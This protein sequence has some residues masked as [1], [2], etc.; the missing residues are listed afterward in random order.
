LD[1]ISLDKV[2]HH[3]FF[4]AKLAEAVPVRSEGLQFTDSFLFRYYNSN[5]G[6]FSQWDKCCKSIKH[7]K[8]LKQSTKYGSI[9][10]LACGLLVYEPVNE[11]FKLV[12]STDGNYLYECSLHVFVNDSHSLSGEKVHAVDQLGPQL[13]K[14][15]KYIMKF[16]DLVKSKTPSV[17][18]IISSDIVCLL[19]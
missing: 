18:N 1:R 3:P 7:L 15:H 6:V 4:Q 16:I 8:P 9:T 19:H 5:V 11:L 17:M 2:L 13:L 14:H 12:L 10:I